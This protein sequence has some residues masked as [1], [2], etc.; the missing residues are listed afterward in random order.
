MSEASGGG[1]SRS[2]PRCWPLTTAGSCSCSY[3]AVGIDQTRDADARLALAPLSAR[4]AARG[5]KKRSTG[6][7]G[8]IPR[9]LDLL[10]TAPGDA[11]SPGGRQKVRTT[12]RTAFAR[13]PPPG[14]CRQRGG[15][16][17]IPAAPQLPN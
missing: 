3:R 8:Y 12:A 6:Y 16:A 7:Q 5:L 14:L 2:L 11:G 10:V 17:M 15:G 13:R 1:R 4:A 9:A